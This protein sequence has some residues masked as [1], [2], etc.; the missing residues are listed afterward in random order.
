MSNKNTDLY[1]DETM[2]NGTMFI[3]KRYIIF[4][5]NLIFLDNYNGQY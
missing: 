2:L 1:G 4:F 3:Y 5:I